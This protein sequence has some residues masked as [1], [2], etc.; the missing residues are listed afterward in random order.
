M[1]R[2][3]VSSTYTDLRQ[4]REAVYKTLRKLGHDAV[5]ME[6]YVATDQRPV[7]KCLADV[8]ASDCYIGIVAWRHG[9]VPP[10]DNA[11]QKSITRLEYDAATTAGKTR[12]VF[13]ASPAVPWPNEYRDHST[14]NSDATAIMTFRRQ[15]ENSLIV[16]HF[17]SA[18][19]LALLVAIAVRKWE[20]QIGRRQPPEALVDQ[21]LPAGL[22]VLSYVPGDHLT[23]RY[24]LPPVSHVLSAAFATAWFALVVIAAISAVQTSSL[25]A[26]G[27]VLAL[28]GAGAWL[29]TRGNRVRF[30]LHNRHVTVFSRTFVS[31][32][33]PI[34]FAIGL[35]HKATK[36]GW[37]T[38]LLYGGLEIGRAGP[39]SSPDVGRA[40]FIRF[41]EA[42]NWE[43]GSHTVTEDRQ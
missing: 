43:L 11:E 32:G 14:G 10:E 30:D 18:T 31:R 2:I 3:Y 40:R 12:L 25:V 36:Q 4:H 17:E 39:H 35:K 1:A 9:F 19:D 7:A 6:D 42:L 38:Y 28:L 20:V 24:R 37:Y 21:E 27:G 41:A 8:I 13:L 5:A 15:L 34:A 16:S 29:A 23:V 22:R 33:R 26:V